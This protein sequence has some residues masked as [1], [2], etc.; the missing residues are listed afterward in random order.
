MNG[1]QEKI[2]HFAIEISPNLRNMRD[3]LRDFEAVVERFLKVTPRAPRQG[4]WE[5]YASLPPEAQLGAIQGIR[6][7]ISFIEGAMASGLDA[8][9]EVAMLD[10][11]KRTFSLISEA[12]P[13][14]S[15]RMGDVVE[16]VDSNLLQVY[17]SYS[18]FSLCNYSLLELT[19]YP[20]YELYER[21]KRVTD[22]L[23]RFSE[24]LIGGK[25]PFVNFEDG[26]F[27]AYNLRELMTEEQEVYS[28]QERFAARLK[29]AHSGENY[30]LSVKRIQPIAQKSGD[31]LAF[32]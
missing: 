25:T 29:S 14:E 17:R 24:G 26:S 21:P 6:S 11:A 23:I 3:T 4:S 7:Q 20:W 31:G 9:N 22:D 13:V 2:N 16:I 15:V 10:Y 8:F 28:I 1:I 32:L 19:S 12:G 27:P 5:K 18:C 30:I